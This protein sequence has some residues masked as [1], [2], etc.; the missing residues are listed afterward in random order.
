[1]PAMVDEN[2]LTGVDMIIGVHDKTSQVSETVDVEWRGVKLTIM[3]TFTKVDT[4]CRFSVSAIQNDLTHTLVHILI[5]H[6][7]R[8]EFVCHISPKCIALHAEHWK[9]DDRPAIQQGIIGGTIPKPN[10]GSL[11]IQRRN[12]HGASFLCRSHRHYK[13]EFRTV[14]YP[15]RSRMTSGEAS[16]SP[17]P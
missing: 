3:T 12:Q 6:K 17:S 9:S 2:S 4:R 16:W 5:V 15:N 1:M 8:E 13:C 7:D 11:Q 10:H 14:V